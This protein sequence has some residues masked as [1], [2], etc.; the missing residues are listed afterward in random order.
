MDR[1]K[2]DLLAAGMDQEEI[3]RQL[4]NFKGEAEL[5]RT[6][7]I[8]LD[9]IHAEF[10]YDGAKQPLEVDENDM[11]LSLKTE[12]IAGAKAKK[13]QLASKTPKQ[14]KMDKIQ[15]D[16]NLNERSH[17]TKK[18]K[19]QARVRTG[20]HDKD[21]IRLGSVDEDDSMT[22]GA[23]G[24]DGPPAAF[25]VAQHEQRRRPTNLTNSN[26][27]PRFNVQQQNVNLNV[28]D[29]AAEDQVV[30]EMEDEDDFSDDVSSSSEGVT[31]AD[32][33]QK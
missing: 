13:L 31:P 3:A 9:E 14:M 22:S 20:M 8:N 1:I 24:S 18:P 19:M 11:A 2:A 12:H 17:V 5:E 16:E 26:T 25:S 32:K 33:T 28:N 7:G 21:S 4:K 29:L 23:A 6:G 27:A 30:E 10:D 15:T